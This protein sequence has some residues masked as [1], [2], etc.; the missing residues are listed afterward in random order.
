MRVDLHP[1]YLL[2]KKAYR[3][4]SYLLEVFS[5]NYGRIGLV[6]KGAATRKSLNRTL[7]PFMPL[8][9]SW[10]GRGELGNLT[11]TEPDGVQILLSGDKLFSGYYVN[12]LLIRLL[13]RHDPHQKLFR[14]YQ[15]ILREIADTT[16]L[17]SVL[18]QFEKRLLEELG[19]GLIL[20]HEIESGNKVLPEGIYD[21]T[22]GIGPVLINSAKVKVNGIKVQG[23]TLLS[24]L[25]DR[26][27]KEKDAR[28]EA[29]QL[30]RYLLTPL[31]GERPLQSRRIFEMMK[32]KEV[33]Q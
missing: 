27:L 20:D 14:I 28:S 3:E 33:L 1:C 13:H 8:L 10:S 19:Y 26:E 18:R 25:S 4:T 2:H 32:S 6:A 7:Q 11:N 9:M 29:K 31:L 22:A 12:E 24:L 16:N 30:M 5:E 21:Y 15:Y 23:T 17:E